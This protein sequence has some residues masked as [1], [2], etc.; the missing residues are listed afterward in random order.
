MS[1]MQG[2]VASSKE[3]QHMMQVIAA[4]QQEMQVK[5]KLKIFKKKPTICTYPVI[6]WEILL[7]IQW[8]GC[9]AVRT[10]LQPNH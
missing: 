7:K 3:V 6:Y 8:F 1:E 9:S 2:P 4:Q 5:K 10:A